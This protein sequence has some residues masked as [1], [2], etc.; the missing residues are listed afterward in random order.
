MSSHMPVGAH[1][2]WFSIYVIL[3]RAFLDL[4]LFSSSLYGLSSPGYVN[5]IDI[6][7][8]LTPEQSSVVTE[9]QYR[10]SASRPR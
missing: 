2:F 8:V 1:I 3:D 10:T 4:L 9:V 7:Y 6:L 5:D